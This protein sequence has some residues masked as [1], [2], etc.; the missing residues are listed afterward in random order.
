[1][2]KGTWFSMRKYFAG[3]A[4][5]VLAVGAFAVASASGE[6]ARAGNM[7]LTFGGNVAPKK[8]PKKRF[9]PIT[10]RLNGHIRTVDGSHP[11]AARRIVLE[12]DRNGT[13]FTNGLPVCK[14]NQL[15]ARTT[16]AALRA[17][18]KALVGR[19]QTKAEIEFAGQ[20]PFTASGPLLIFNGPRKGRQP[21]IV[22]HVYAAVPA[23]TAFV[24]RAKVTNA[25]SRRFGKRVEIR[26]PTITGGAG[27]LTDFTSKVYRAW[28]HKGKKR[29]Y[30]IARCSNGRF[31]AR[32]ELRFSDGTTL[33]R[34]V[35]RSCRAR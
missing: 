11:P 7:V 27:S 26:V 29:S 13:L 22:M 10:L 4:S 1:M 14:P 25:K 20:A 9:A 5:A 3:M 24:V 18:R 6:T 23:P 31:V 17:C 12:F 19:G 33:A 28:T 8:L 32:G 35:V 2:E 16:K 30:L 15:E 21:S 34:N